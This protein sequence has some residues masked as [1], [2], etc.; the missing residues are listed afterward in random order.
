MRPLSIRLLITDYPAI[1]EECDIRVLDIIYPGEELS[2]LF[3][4]GFLCG[5][6][7]LKLLRKVRGSEFKDPSND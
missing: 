7:C 4:T 1:A 2:H 3:G 6:D 5:T